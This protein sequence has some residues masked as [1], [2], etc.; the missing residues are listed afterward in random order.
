M[1]KG[2]F[3][4]GHA[5]AL[6][7][8]IEAEAA[9][10]ADRYA[11]ALIPNRFAEPRENPSSASLEKQ[12]VPLDWNPGSAV[13]ARALVLAAENRIGDID[14]AIL[15]CSPP[16]VP[17]AAADLKPVDIEVL[18]SDHVKS[19][20]FLAR[21]LVSSFKM[22]KRGMLVLVYPEAGGAGGKEAVADILGS[23]AMASFRSLALGLLAGASS[24]AYAAQGF[25][26]GEAGNEEGFANF[27][28]RQLDDTKRRIN[29]KL[30]KF[31]KAG[32]FK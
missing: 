7:G 24:E 25:A 18:A 17:C 26:G 11:L 31:G 3:I 14:E 1:T 28:F 9:K 30:H 16:S 6:L 23:V 5:S 19:W 12:R 21:E 2:I 20:L 10:R 29:G 15:A 22:K 27:I 4:A 13:S 32:F 8:A